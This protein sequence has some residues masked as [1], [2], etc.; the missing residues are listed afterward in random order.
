MDEQDK[1]LEMMLEE[2]EGIL[3]RIQ[4][5]DISLE[6]SFTLYQQG[7][8]ILKHCNARI[9]AVEK[10]LLVLNENGQLGELP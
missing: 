6:D 10:K 4:Q 9:D 2:A 5:R 7:I 3:G 1:T 8:E